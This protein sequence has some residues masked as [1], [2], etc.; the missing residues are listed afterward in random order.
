MR[1]LAEKLETAIENVFDI[2]VCVAFKGNKIIIN[3]VADKIDELKIYL[4]IHGYLYAT[5]FKNDQIKL[6]DPLT[7]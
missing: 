1:T 6:Y 7:G 2:R 3:G 4:F 5:K